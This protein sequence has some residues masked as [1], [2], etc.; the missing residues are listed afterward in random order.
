[1][2]VGSPITANVGG[3]FPGSVKAQALLSACYGKLRQAELE[4]N[5]W[6]FATRRT[7]LRAADTDTMALAPTLWSSA[8]TYFVGSIVSDSN[9]TWW[10]SRL[11]SNT[12][13]Q[14]GSAFAAWDIYSGPSTA[15]LYSGTTTYFASELVYTAPGDGTYGVFRSLISG[16]GLD[17]S[18]PNIW[19]GS[20]NY[21]Q[22]QVVQTFPAWSSGTTYSQG[23]TVLYTDGNYYSSL[24]NSNHN[25]IP[26]STINTDWALM[27]VLMLQPNAPPPAIGQPQ[28]VQPQTSPVVEWSAGT[29]MNGVFTAQT[30]SIGSYVM[31]GGN[32]YVSLQN[33]NT[34]KT[35]NAA[36]STYWAEVTGGTLWMSLI[37]LNINNN[38]TSTPA[39]WSSV[40]TYTTG[41][42]VAASDGY[43]YTATAAGG[44]LGQNPANNANPTYWTQGGLTA[45][46]STFT[47][48]GGNQQWTQIGGSQFPYGVGLTT[49]NLIY[50]LG[51]GPSSDQSTRNVFALPANF[52]REAPQDPKAGSVSWLGAPSGQVYN[53]WVLENGFIVTGQ[54]DPIVYRFVADVQNVQNFDAMFCEGLGCRQAVEICE[55]LTQSAAKLSI[56][57]KEYEK[58]MGEARARAGIEQGPTEPPQDDYLT[59]RL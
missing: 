59:C 58:F 8:A 29:W 5:V 38:P 9:G 12:N 3:A 16:N 27:P 36:N 35:P 41:N 1:M 44:N 7:P 6:T 43:N 33:N 22:N 56:I 20:A 55:P 37:K 17:P 53:D 21:Q 11:A 48:G 57:A 10:E 2:H 32:E 42:V 14:P 50:P 4:R 13:N 39:T 46:T 18:L 28:T 49:L 31:F 47:Q 23:Q 54:S 40:T 30:Y 51:A 52:L 15:E 19:S 24:I 25:N 34:G 45:W 26:A